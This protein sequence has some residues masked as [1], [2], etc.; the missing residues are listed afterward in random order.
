MELTDPDYF[1]NGLWLQITQI[2]KQFFLHILFN[3]SQSNDAFASKMI[4]IALKITLKA[5]DLSIK[6]TRT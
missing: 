4:E 2:V 1:P 3:S 5:T 6:Y